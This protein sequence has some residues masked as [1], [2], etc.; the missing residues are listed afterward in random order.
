MAENE[1]WAAW[2]VD[3]WIMR[4]RRACGCP[5]DAFHPIGGVKAATAALVVVVPP[6]SSSSAD[7]FHIRIPGSTSIEC[8]TSESNERLSPRRNWG[9]EL[10]PA[11]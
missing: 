3:E 2:K 10:I 8:V 4:R 7:S 6:G 1:P 9:A 11:V 5:D